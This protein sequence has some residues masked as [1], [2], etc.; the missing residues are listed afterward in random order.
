MYTTY[1]INS[2]DLTPDFIEILKRTYKDKE[3]E[4]AVSEIDETDYLLRSQKNREILISRIDDLKKGINI[5]S[6]NIEEFDEKHLL[7]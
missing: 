7:S 6:T 1:Q 3:I 4:I 5:V 2:K